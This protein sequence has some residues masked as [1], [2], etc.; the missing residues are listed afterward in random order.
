MTGPAATLI[1]VFTLAAV[2][3]VRAEPAN[4][5]GTWQMGVEGDHVVPIGLTLKQDGRNLTGTIL[6]PTQQAGQRVEVELSGE[7]V[8][9]ALTLSGT[10]ANAKEPTKIDLLATL[11]E[12][13]TLKGTISTPHGTMPWTAERLRGPTPAA[14]V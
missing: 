8:D 1:A 5:T 13:G 3:P 9:G 6:L 11:N 12:D 7:F 4:L 2:L 10:V 14:R